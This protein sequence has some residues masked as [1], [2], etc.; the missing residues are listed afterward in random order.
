MYEYPLSTIHKEIVES[1]L[2]KK[3]KPLFIKGWDGC[4]KSYLSKHLLRDYHIVE[5]NSDHLK[6]SDIE[7]Y[8][9][10]TLFRKNI[11]MMCHG[12]P[13]K[14]L[15]LD[16][17]QLFISYDKINLK[18]IY[19][20]LKSLDYSK[21]PTIIVCNL[22]HHKYINMLGNMSYNITLSHNNSFYKSII[23]SRVK[24]RLSNTKLNN[25]VDISNNNL[26]IM[27]VNLS[28]LKNDKDIN[29]T[30]E[31]IIN[32]LFTR[33]HTI[34]DVFRYFSSEYNVIPL[35]LLENIPSLIRNNY[36][37]T[38]YSVYEAICIGDYIESKYLDKNLDMDIAILF[39]CVKP[40]FYTKGSMPI[41]TNYK[42]KY[43]SYIGRS[44]IQINNQSILSSSSIDYMKLLTNL[45]GYGV[46]LSSSKSDIINNIHS[47]RSDK[48]F[49][50]KILEK[51]IKVFNYY[52][53]KTMTRKQL[54]KLLKH[55]NIIYGII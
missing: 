31:E 27:N 54:H 46:L 26:N 2:S 32:I 25:I 34:S 51:Q 20:L 39:L 33:N 7:G 42:Y 16:D 17:L 55:I 19:N 37:H 9:K 40:Y 41:H 28:N 52:Y 30:I 45:Y 50:I 18:K 49:N 29:Y 53:N 11:L 47:I 14:A 36:I 35:N 10:N 48:E 15:L 38:L 24:G 22:I 3:D 4:G 23:R 6:K 13:Y 44:I 1:W 21:Y 12:N 5:I 43:N 8:I